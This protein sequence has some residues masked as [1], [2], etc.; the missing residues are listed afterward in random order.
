MFK[1]KLYW[2][3]W[4]RVHFTQLDDIERVFFQADERGVGPHQTNLRCP[5]YMP[6]GQQFAVRTVQII[7]GTSLERDL[8]RLAY[9]MDAERCPILTDMQFNRYDDARV[10][11]VIGSTTYACDTLGMFRG[12][13]YSLGAVPLIIST[14]VNFAVCIKFPDSV[15][16]KLTHPVTIEVRLLGELIRAAT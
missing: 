2:P 7:V 10:R 6:P 13:G 12:A 15:Y 3:L 5:G 9:A 1:E 4:H 8:V 14:Q 11:L 16:G